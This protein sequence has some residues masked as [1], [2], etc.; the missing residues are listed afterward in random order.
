MTE[1]EFEKIF[2]SYFTVLSN[3]AYSVVKDKDQAKDVVQQ[4]FIKF[5]DKRNS[6]NIR[7]E[8]K[9]Y[10]HRAVINTSL[11]YI[12]RNKKLKLEDDFSSFDRSEDS[13]PGKSE[14]KQQKLAVNIKN[15]IAELP[16]KCQ[17]VFSLSRYEGMTNREIAEYL[18]I[19]LKAVEK[20]VSRALRE[21]RVTLK[22]YV[23]LISI[24]F[25]IEVGFL[26]L[27]MFLK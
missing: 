4:V 26:T 19:S 16:E 9:S 6:I 24:L 1:P 23:N 18:G 3:I 11:N 7:N 12:E 27:D 13:D 8:I 2:R 22:P 25:M 21:L 10:L 14:L 15:A 5:W 17:L 20:H